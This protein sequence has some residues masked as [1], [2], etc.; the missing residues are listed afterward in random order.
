LETGGKRPYL[1]VYLGN[2]WEIN[3]IILNSFGNTLG[4]QFIDN[5]QKTS[6]NKNDL[7]NNLKTIGKHFDQIVNVILMKH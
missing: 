7:K 4:N 5:W 6:K 2:N 3:L 1:G